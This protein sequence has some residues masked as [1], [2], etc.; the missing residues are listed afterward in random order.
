[1]RTVLLVVAQDGFQELEYAN[2]K[3]ELLSAGYSV[4]TA[5]RAPGDARSHMG[6]VVIADIAIADVRPSDYAG[7]FLVGGEGAPR[8]L[9]DESVYRCMLAARDSGILHGAICYSPRVLAHAGVLEG[10]HATG[11]NGD[12][13]LE[14]IITAG[15]GQYAA[16]PVVRD[17]ILITADGPLSSREFG[18]AIVEALRAGGDIA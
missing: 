9:E 8:Y 11:W 6:T 1:M 10:K 18:A 17:G 3:R 5:A 4:V 13:Q 16:D 14:G 2:P 12:G 7:I 15:G